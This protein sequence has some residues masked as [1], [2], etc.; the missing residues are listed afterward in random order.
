MGWGSRSRE[1]KWFTKQGMVMACFLLGFLALLY[2][3]VTHSA[4]LSKSFW[5]WSR[6]SGS[7]YD[8]FENER[9][10]T[11]DAAKPSATPLVTSSP[12]DENIVE[13]FPRVAICLVGGARAFELTGLSIKQHVLDVYNNSDVFL[14]VPLDY[15]AHKLT[16]LKHASRLVMAKV[17]ANDPVPESNA[18]REVLTGANSP[19]GIQGLL[20]YFRLVEGCL[21]MI[22]SYETKY[23][24]KYDWIIRTRV[25]G[26]W[27]GP[28]PPLETL[29]PK[30]YHVPYGSKFGG[31][32]DRL[33]IGTRNTS[34]VAL[35]RLSLIPKLHE[36][37]YRFLNS[38]QAFKHQFDVSNV[39]VKYDDFRFCILT[40]R[41]YAW[42]LTQWGVPVA[43]IKSKGALNGAKCKP[44]HPILSGDAASQ[45]LKALDT[46][47]GWINPV[48]E[49][50]LCDSRRDLEP[51]WET[52]FDEISGP[53]QAHVR[54][55]LTN[56]TEEQCIQEIYQFGQLWEV[57][58]APIPEVMCQRYE[59]QTEI[60]E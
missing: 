19:H 32:N 40:K 25:D 58:D 31:L 49:L 35:S 59:Q 5:G 20:Q 44:C 21:D 45:A 23:R 22:S 37:G 54:Q 42:P 41:K 27:S 6:E 4:D 29:S 3:T 15:D 50:E 10:R 8:Q 60:S 36:R 2:Q 38:E 12:S 52:V 18:A 7:S 9:V 51:G 30:Y 47:W 33:G 28:L 46:G 17:F 48:K 14:H 57:W 11:L 1:Q 43:S 39:K 56:R 55:W 26:Y 13:G 53:Q 16:L 34:W 24:F